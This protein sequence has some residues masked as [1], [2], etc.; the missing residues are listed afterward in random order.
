MSLC[1]RPMP[2]PKREPGWMGR[3]NSP[4]SFPASTMHARLRGTMH[5][6]Q[7]LEVANSPVTNLEFPLPIVGFAGRILTEDGGPVPNPALFSEVVLSTAS[8]PNVVSS[9]AL[10]I[11]PQGTFGAVL[12]KGDYQLSFRNVPQGL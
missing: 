8:N 1:L 12:E 11:S 7:A 2:C 9:R 6:Y 5:K 10:S 4:T 3:S